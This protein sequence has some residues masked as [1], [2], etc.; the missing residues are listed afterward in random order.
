MCNRPELPDDCDFP[1]DDESKMNPHESKVAWNLDTEPVEDVFEY[2]FTC[3][4]IEY[5]YSIGVL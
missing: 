2:L 4:C 5:L 1:P 3:Y